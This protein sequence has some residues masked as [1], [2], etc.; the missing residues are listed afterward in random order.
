MKKKP[1]I[2]LQ[3]YAPPKEKASLVEKIVL[4]VLI[5]ALV[6]AVGFGVYNIFTI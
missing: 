6:F 2:I 4:A 1:T 5:A 3:H